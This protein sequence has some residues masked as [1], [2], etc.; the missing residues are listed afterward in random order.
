MEPINYLAQVADP[1]AQATQ[2]LQLGA[3]MAELQQKQALMAQQQQRQQLAVQEQA[4]F[5]SNPKPTMRDAARYASLLTPEQANAF[6]PFM[7]GISKEQQQGILKSTGQTLSALQLNPEIGINKLKQDALAARNSGDMEDAAL[8]ERLAEAAADPKQGKAVV[9]QSLVARTAG[10]PGAKEMYETFAKGMETADAAAQAPA[11]LRQEL[12]AAEKAESDAK[13]ALATADNAAAIAKA[14][15]DLK[16]AQAKKAEIESLYT[17]RQQIADL[18]AKNLTAGLTQAQTQQALATASEKL[19]S[20]QNQLSALPEAAQKLVNESAQSAAVSKQASSQYT[21]LAKQLDSLGNSWGALNNLGEWSKSQFGNQDFRT[22][23]QNE[24]TRLANSAGIKAYKAAGATGGF[25]DA[26]LNTALQG[27][28]KAN[29]NPQIMAQ[30][31]RGMAKEQAIAAALDN[32]KTDWLTQNKGQL[33]RANKPFIAGDY[34]VKPGETYADF[35]ERATRDVVKK[36]T[37]PAQSSMVQ[38]IPTDANP[39]P[40]AATSSIEAQADAII[41]GGR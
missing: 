17:E 2:G 21:D 28:P 9:F 5:F 14:D 18:R 39:R 27:I 15:A 12:A 36:F 19:A 30:F 40:M 23:I 38:Q 22:A 24:Y 10:I 4:R 34:S 37:T 13:T 33:G 8:F 6:R 26:D 20:I 16:K 25:S 11:K 29:A 7:E 41:R 1:F 31:L 32:A 35:A 3:G